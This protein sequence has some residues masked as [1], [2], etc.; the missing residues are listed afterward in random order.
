MRAVLGRY[1]ANYAVP[2][3]PWART[4][5]ATLI[6]Q[7]E[8]CEDTARLLGLEGTAAGVYSSTFRRLN[9]SALPFD[10]R[11]TRPPRDPVNALLS[12]A[13]TLLTQHTVGLIE[14]HG[15]DPQIGFYHEVHGRRPSLALDLIEPL[16]HVVVDRAV[17]RLINLSQVGAGDFTPVTGGCHVARSAWPRVIDAFE[18]L[19]DSRP[20]P[21]D[22]PDTLQAGSWR[23]WLRRRIARFRQ[24]LA[25][26]AGA[27]LAADD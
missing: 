4:R 20:A 2:G 19:L 6:R 25:V 27:D 17:L 1:Q 24:Q 26:V 10:G 11:S 14:A 22:V 9:R 21:A 3:L 12:L 23:E 18:S 7:C 15:L 5:L 13:Y 16:R 8:T